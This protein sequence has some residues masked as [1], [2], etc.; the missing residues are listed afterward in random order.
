MTKREDEGLDLDAIEER[1]ARATPG[2]WLAMC[3]VTRFGTIRRVEYTASGL[4]KGAS[5]IVA[6]ADASEGGDAQNASNATFI[7]A[8]RED[9]PRLVARVR[10]LEARGYDPHA[11]AS[12]RRER[13]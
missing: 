4:N 2:P 9:V 7:A 5:F 11:E 12:T 10:E 13:P 8:A 1:A 3:H 6:N